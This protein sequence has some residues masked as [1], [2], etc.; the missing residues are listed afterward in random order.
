MYDKSESTGSASFVTRGN[1]MRRSAEE[2]PKQVDKLLQDIDDQQ[3][4]LKQM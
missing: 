1:A 3:L 2:K 4:V